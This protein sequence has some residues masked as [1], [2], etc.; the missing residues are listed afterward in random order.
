M[1]FR[2]W[3]NSAYQTEATIALDASRRLDKSDGLLAALASVAAAD[4]RQL[5]MKASTV[6]VL[7]PSTTL[8]YQGSMLARRGQ[9][10]GNLLVTLRHQYNSQLGIEVGTTA[11]EPK[12]LTTKISYALDKHSAVNFDSTLVS[13]YLPPLFNLTYATRVAD[14]V[15]CFA[16]V[17]SGS[18][19]S[20]LSALMPLFQPFAG[21]P[22]TLMVGGTYAACTVEA[23]ANQFGEVA[24]S[25]N[26]GNVRL[27]GGG[28]QRGWKL[29]TNVGAN[30]QGQAT[31]GVS[32]EKRLTENTH[33]GIGMGVVVTTG[34]L[35]L[36]LRVNRLG[37]R[38][39]VPILLSSAASPRL[40]LGTVFIPA[41]S[42]ASMQYF[43]LTPR[44]TRQVAERLKRLRE[45]QQEDMAEKR[46]EALE[47]I[48]LLREQTERKAE[49][50][51]A[52]DGLVI[53]EA[54]YTGT[55]SGIEPDEVRK[56]AL[57]VRIPVQALI[58]A[59]HGGNEAESTSVLAIPGGRSKAQ[60]IGFYDVMVGSKKKLLI[61]YTFRGRYHEASFDDFQPVALP[62]RSHLVE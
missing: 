41:V 62:M 39:S 32:T 6:S 56:S 7:T 2:I 21:S 8:T 19:Y 28:R 30:S 45:E 1:R 37:Q 55:G 9:G 22:S 38:L 15:D 42:I 16:R 29:S 58:S 60:L 26:Y 23:T 27:L 11:L 44:S 52:K 51:R 49:S 59:R 5:F 50:E 31:F 61:K 54:I 35:T 20:F 13:P 46:K 53:V 24:V 34:A 33:I 12:R 57:D 18:S 36:R 17:S 48:E 3:A 40:I 10:G 14:K 43:Y 4:V 47:A 25:G